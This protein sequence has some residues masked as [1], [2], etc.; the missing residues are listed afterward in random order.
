MIGMGLAG[1]DPARIMPMLEQF[2]QAMSEQGGSATI[3]EYE[4]A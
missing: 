3:V 4:K 1:G 2:A